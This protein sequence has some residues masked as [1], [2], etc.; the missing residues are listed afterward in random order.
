MGGGGHHGDDH[1]WMNPPAA[2]RFLHFFHR[3]ITSHIDPPRTVEHGSGGGPSPRNIQAHRFALEIR[4]DR[5]AAQLTAP[6]ALLKSAERHGRVK[7]IVPI[8]PDGAR[9]EL[10]REPEDLADV[11]TPDAGREAV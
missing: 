3:Y 8:P 1:G 10:G 11:A 2:R 5:L 6:A 9:T 7:Q 4:I